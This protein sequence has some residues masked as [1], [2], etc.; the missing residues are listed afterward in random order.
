M[1]AVNDIDF[2]ALKAL[3]AEGA[4]PNL[5]ND[6]GETALM[7]AAGIGNKSMVEMLLAAG[8][9]VQL[10]DSCGETALAHAIKTEH[11]EVADLLRSYGAKG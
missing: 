3:L 2:A 9:D 10:R 11:P 7:L 6:K 4:L 5:Q 1:I 8:A